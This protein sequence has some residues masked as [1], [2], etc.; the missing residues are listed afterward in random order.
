[1]PKECDGSKG[2]RH[3]RIVGV[4]NEQDADSHKRLRLS[5]PVRIGYLEHAKSVFILAFFFLNSSVLPVK[6]DAKNLDRHQ[7]CHCFG[8]VGP[9]SRH[10]ISSPTWYWRIWVFH[11]GR[12]QR[13]GG[14]LLQST[15]ASWSARGKS[16]HQPGHKIR[17][18]QPPHR[19]R[20]PP[21]LVQN[22]SPHRCYRF[23]W[24]QLQ[25]RYFLR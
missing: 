15:Y 18:R 24:R 11:I 23:D 21:C 10:R 17:P 7:Y 19:P 25:Q 14:I 8:A 16:Q 13:C 20:W 9:G 4:F 2:I 5:R 3:V 12:W 1:M 22:P 6:S